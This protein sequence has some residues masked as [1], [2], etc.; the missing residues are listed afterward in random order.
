MPVDPCD[1]NESYQATGIEI[2]FS[3]G[4]FAELI[5]INGFGFERPSVESTH[6]KSPSTS[7]GNGVKHVHRQFSPSVLVRNK[8]LS[9]VV[10]HR[11]GVKAPLYNK[12]EDVIIIFPDGERISYLCASGAGGFIS[13]FS[14]D[15]NAIQDELVQATFQLTLTGVP[16]HNT[17]PTTTTSTT[18]TT[19]T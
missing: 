10:Y 14:A 6:S 13:D 2:Q 1:D 15:F 4:Y 12:K 16:V 9:V 3:S 5:S 8:P 19:T 17:T 11:K 18:T 7:E